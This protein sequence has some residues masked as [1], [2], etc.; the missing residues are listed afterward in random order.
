MLAALTGVLAAVRVQGDL[1]GTSIVF[2][3]TVSAIPGAVYGQ[4]A[5]LL[6]ISVSAIPN[7]VDGTLASL[8]ISISAIPNA[9]DGTLS[10][11][12]VS[13]TGPTSIPDPFFANNNLLLHF[14][15][16]NGS[17][18]Y[19]DTSQYARSPVTTGSTSI[20][21]AQWK[22]NGSALS[23]PGGE[24]LMYASDP[25]W[26][27]SGINFTIEFW[28]F[29]SVA[30]AW[31][32]RRLSGASGWVF[33]NDGIRANINGVWSDLQIV[34]TV[35]PLNTW[36]HYALTVS[37]GTMRAFIDGVLVGTKTGVTVID[38]QPRPLTFGQADG[39][40]KKKVG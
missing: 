9:V 39:L 24:P 22:F 5:A 38:D 32:C 37:S 2:P 26:S 33:S 7:A 4:T 17:T 12:P 21:T 20:S 10:M 40:V 6:Q 34:W 15:G 30:G 16:S 19:T 28:G 8:P 27:L 31:L 29:Q 3:V 11:L 13:V 25:A 36:H 18:T 23:S 1:T 35:P 14:D